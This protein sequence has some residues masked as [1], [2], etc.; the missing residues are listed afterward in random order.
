MLSGNDRVYQSRTCFSLIV[1][2]EQ[3]DDGNIR[4]T[5]R[6]QQPPG[7]QSKGMREECFA[8]QMNNSHR[9]AGLW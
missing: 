3:W 4:K 2:G 1:L 6:A 5:T 9:F 7:G 8:I